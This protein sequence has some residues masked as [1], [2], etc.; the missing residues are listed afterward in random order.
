[1][2]MC[3]YKD[4]IVITNRKLCKRPFLKQLQRVL[5][6]Q[7]AGIIL[8]EKDLPPEDY[9]HLAG[10]VM[11]LCRIYGV[12]C[13]LHTFLESALSLGCKRIHL[14][15]RDFPFDQNQMKGFH[16]IGVSIHSA[17]EA[18]WAANL[19]ATYITAGH[20]FATSCKP[21]LNPRGLKF[22]RQICHTVTIPVY[23]IGGIDQKNI[24]DVLAC[25]AAKGCIM[26]SAM[27]I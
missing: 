23:G 1:M 19:G 18:I 9:S 14:S 20:V 21:G 10:Q 8:R 16:Q 5:E 17:E 11:E 2:I 6:L 4:F 27:L 13:T 22:L 7:P 3:N 26:S 12:P 25:G 15:S 24:S